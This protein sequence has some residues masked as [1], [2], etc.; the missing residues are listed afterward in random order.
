MEMGGRSMRGWLR[1]DADDVQTDKA[2]ATWVERGV[3]YAR[4]LPA[5]R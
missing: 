1:V 3:S 5:K 4:T 2:L